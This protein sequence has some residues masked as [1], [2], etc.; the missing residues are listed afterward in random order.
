MIKNW[1][2]FNESK[3]L[4]K[5]VKDNGGEILAR[6]LMLNYT[7]GSTDPDDIFDFYEDLAKAV[8]DNELEEKRDGN[9]SFIKLKEKDSE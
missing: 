5:T 6:D 9:T 7:D 3:D 2:K 8:D 4:V 1:K